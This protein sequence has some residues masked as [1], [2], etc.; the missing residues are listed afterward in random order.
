M[1]IV[2]LLFV[3][4]TSLI[5]AADDIVQLYE[6]RIQ[7]SNK[8]LDAFHQHVIEILHAKP[9][10]ASNARDKLSEKLLR[11]PTAAVSAPDPFREELFSLMSHILQP[12]QLLI[13]NQRALFIGNPLLENFAPFNSR[14]L[15]LRNFCEK[16]QAI[17]AY[18][19]SL[20][21][22]INQLSWFSREWDEFTLNISEKIRQF[23]LSPLDLIEI[24]DKFIY[25]HTQQTHLTTIQ[26]TLSKQL[27][28]TES[29]IPTSFGCLE[30][31]RLSLM[32]LYQRTAKVLWQL[33]RNSINLPGLA[34]NYQDIPST[35]FL[36]K[37]NP[38]K[39][40]LDLAAQP[41]DEETTATATS[42]SSHSPTLS[43]ARSDPLLIPSEDS[44]SSLHVAASASTSTT[45]STTEQLDALL[46]LG[47]PAAKIVAPSTTP[48]S[49]I[50]DPLS[51]PST[52]A[53]SESSLAQRVLPS[54]STD[55][56]P[57]R[58]PPRSLARAILGTSSFTPPRSEPIST[59][60]TPTTSK[61]VTPATPIKQR[62][63]GSRILGSP[64]TR[65][66]S[67]PA[68]MK[69]L[70]GALPVVQDETA[71]LEVFGDG[72]EQIHSFI[73]NLREAFAPLNWGDEIIEFQA[74]A[75]FLTNA[76]FIMEPIEVLLE[77]Y[78][79]YEKYLL[80]SLADRELILSPK[81]SVS[82][83]GQ[84]LL[85]ISQTTARQI[86][87]L[88]SNGPFC[89]GF[90]Q[91]TAESQL[92]IFMSQRI[93]DLTFLRRNR[94]VPGVVGKRAA[95]YT[96]AHLFGIPC[97]PFAFAVIDEILTL[98]PKTQRSY[99]GVGALPNQDTLTRE[100][101]SNSNDWDQNNEHEFIVVERN[102]SSFLNDNC[103]LLSDWL[104]QV[105]C[106]KLSF[107]SLDAESYGMLTLFCIL[108]QS[109]AIPDH[110]VVMRKTPHDK[111]TFKL[112]N[113]NAFLQPNFKRLSVEGLDVAIHQFF[114][115]NILYMLPPAGRQIP[116]EVIRRFAS[117]NIFLLLAQAAKQNKARQQEFDGYD[118]QY[119]LSQKQDSNIDSATLGM[120]FG[121]TMSAIPK[122]NSNLAADFLRMVR[123]FETPAVSYLDILEELRA[124][125]AHCYDIFLDQAHLT[126]LN[127]RTQHFINK[128]IPVVITQLQSLASLSKGLGIRCE[129][130]DEDISNFIAAAKQLREKLKKADE[131]NIS[132]SF[133][134]LI[135][136]LPGKTKFFFDQQFRRADET[137]VFSTVACQHAWEELVGRADSL[138][139][140]EG[141]VTIS[142]VDD[143]L[144]TFMPPIIEE[145][146]TASR[147]T[148][149]QTEI[150]SFSATE[151]EHIEQAVKENRKSIK[152]H[153][154]IHFEYM[155][156]DLPPKI[157]EFFRKSYRRYLHE[158]KPVSNAASSSAI[159]TLSRYS[160]FP[161]RVFS[162]FSWDQV[163]VSTVQGR[164]IFAAMFD[165]TSSIDEQIAD[166]AACSNITDMPMFQALELLDILL[167]LNDKIKTPHESWS[168]VITFARKEFMALPSNI[169]AFL[170]Q[171]GVHHEEEKAVI[172]R[173][174]LRRAA[175]YGSLLS[176]ASPKIPTHIVTED[177]SL[178]VPGFLLRVMLIG[179]LVDRSQNIHESQFLSGLADM[180]LLPRYSPIQKTM[181]LE[182]DPG[183][184]G[185]TLNPEGREGIFELHT[186]VGDHYLLTWSEYFA[187]LRYS[188]HKLS[189]NARVHVASHS[190][191]LLLLHWLKALQTTCPSTQFHPWYVK[192]LYSTLEK[193]QILLQNREIL[194]HQSLSTVLPEVAYVMD[195]MF[196]SAKS[197][198]PRDLTKG[199]Q[200]VKTENV[201]KNLR[202]NHTD[203]SQ[204][205]VDRSKRVESSNLT[206]VEVK[207]SSLDC[208]M[209]GNQNIFTLLNEW[210]RTRE[211]SIA[212][213]PLSLEEA[214]TVILNEVNPAKCGIDFL[215][216]TLSLASQCHVVLNKVNCQKW[217]NPQILRDL[218]RLGAPMS[219]IQ[220]A[221]SLR[222]GYPITFT[223]TGKTI[224]IS[225][226][227]DTNLL[228][229]L[230]ALFPDI[231]ELKLPGNY[232]GSLM[233][234]SR[235]L[236]EL[237]ALRILDLSDNPF[238]NVAPLADL[239][240]LQR[241]NLSCTFVA[242][243]SVDDLRT[244][245]LSQ[246]NCFSLPQRQ[247]SLGEFMAIT[248]SKSKVVYFPELTSANYENRCSEICQPIERELGQ[249]LELTSNDPLLVQVATYMKLNNP[250][251][252]ALIAYILS[253]I[254]ERR[255]DFAVGNSDISYQRIPDYVPK[256]WARIKDLDIRSSV[257]RLLF[258]LGYKL[259]MGT[260]CQ[261][262]IF[263][264][265]ANGLVASSSQ[266]SL[267]TRAEQLP[268]E[269]IDLLRM[270]VKNSAIEKS[271]FTHFLPL[272]RN[273][274]MLT[275]VGNDMP[276]L[277]ESLPY[278]PNLQLLDV[279]KNQLV[280][281]RGLRTTAMP[282]QKFPKLAAFIAQQNQIKSGEDR[283]N[284]NGLG[285]ILELEDLTRVD[286][287]YNQ[288]TTIIPLLN[289]TFAFLDLRNNHIPR[290][291]GRKDI[292][293]VFYIEEQ[294]E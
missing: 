60:T 220:L 152:A 22:A 67:A 271:F 277:L 215:D 238:F 225:G 249:A 108:T 49:Q 205:H 96:L 110:I 74:L 100:Y 289:K 109:K 20:L 125:E 250:N 233:P 290:T 212:S 161:S 159:V 1:Q 19:E 201:L 173:A 61:R 183:C 41:V 275:L 21:I 186:R 126:I 36:Q 102:P 97:E 148:L 187:L 87:S 145:L 66:A 62:D 33:L 270:H 255:W 84:P 265:H 269:P 197:I 171:H 35:Y 151:I 4:F 254:A 113:Y 124:P 202:E 286:L 103:L 208:S 163:P 24:Y 199:P 195:Q 157:K 156:L 127:T 166:L 155:I 59:R 79:E 65:A 5:S 210:N 262:L 170:R 192:W 76:K 280:S 46:P 237:N 119:K 267:S 268:Y 34:R 138:I 101:L 279:S 184:L 287:R 9:D 47:T 259:P 128:Y 121:L 106:G 16:W 229:E 169:M 32:A 45:A 141:L 240:R 115:Q 139:T 219:S 54:T 165:A 185:L 118:A 140:Y 234:I 221:V 162:S 107:D 51:L 283:D 263:Q 137:G 31:I 191:V 209:G 136:D 29:V 50:Q 82:L 294:R 44:N 135:A 160:A 278:M 68:S 8:E 204:R 132:I 71:T 40:Y 12:E 266:T 69:N 10:V 63:S 18:S 150:E 282:P 228:C 285:Y 72:S 211:L 11:L 193:L 90:H 91:E 261:S 14:A 213:A 133:A 116:P 130:S 203:F 94:F 248:T 88:Q 176:A 123:K 182:T 80:K 48:L 129:F 181:E 6:A 114:G 239:T 64:I 214:A 158:K 75:T 216:Y 153:D 120:S 26:A 260:Q 293:K 77:S 53:S 15:P 198:D 207:G 3:I 117:N 42:S 196:T 70:T 258:A 143:F 83:F 57:V 241:L 253:R 38:L 177:D 95:Q 13:D 244:L 167:R 236:Q 99:G 56:S 146:K 224:T 104:E 86:C 246:Q 164:D 89:F 222:A 149:V 81:A 284:Y 78:K 52:P 272:C 273:M 98:K 256:L 25:F 178:K 93:A 190:P 188:Q 251:D 226:T 232:L 147:S 105:S 252:N 37:S 288:L 218:M 55:S 172:E 122:L 179:S 112:I 230:I 73:Q 85:R 39:K 7:E 247:V 245:M 206:P 242:P 194:F 111:F 27:Q 291:H 175:E 58:T 28:K 180:L 92:S 30:T 200:E 174:Q 154:F 168:R 217:N 189:D 235:T 23:S 144:E 281:L 223:R 274:R 17:T 227:R 257:K 131:E 264:F 43:V 142:N 134:D 231:D 292:D 243:G 2:A 276:T